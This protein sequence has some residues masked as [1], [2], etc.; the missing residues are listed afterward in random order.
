MK[1]RLTR[2]ARQD[3]EEIGAYIRDRNPAAAIKVRDEIAES[4]RV[5]GDHPLIGRDLGGQLRRLPLPRAPYLVFYRL[6]DASGRP[7]I[8]TIRHAARTPEGAG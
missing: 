5:I 8:V 1:P 3:I 4:L 6:D 7:V 2:Q